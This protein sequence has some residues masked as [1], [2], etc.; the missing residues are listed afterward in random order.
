MYQYTILKTDPSIK[1]D[2]FMKF[3]HSVAKQIL[4]VQICLKTDHVCKEMFEKQILFVKV[5]R[6]DS[7]CKN[8]L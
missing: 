5:F 2:T 6:K 3:K 8:T 4:F 7:V 1:K